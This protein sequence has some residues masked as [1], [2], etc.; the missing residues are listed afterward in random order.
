VC[1]SM[2]VRGA[3]DRGKWNL[4]NGI[5]MICMHVSK[6]LFSDAETFRSRI[7]AYAVSRFHFSL[8][9]YIDTV[10]VLQTSSNV[11]TTSSVF[12]LSNTNDRFYINIF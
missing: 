9:I 8:L 11:G 1:V 2:Y 5:G 6:T 3:G 4:H 10:V 12:F 7:L